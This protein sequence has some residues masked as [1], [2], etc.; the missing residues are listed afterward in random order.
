MDISLPDA[1]STFFQVSNGAAPSSLRRA[2][3]EKAVVHDEGQTY[4]GHEAIETWL[5]EA[6]RKYA[7]SV[8]PLTFVQDDARV[9]VVAQYAGNFPGGL[10]DLKHVFRL[11]DHKIEF[12]EIH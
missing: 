5:A 12:L 10:A 11:T 4:Q 1:V 9:T 2:F 8:E 3:S 6:Q 7:Y